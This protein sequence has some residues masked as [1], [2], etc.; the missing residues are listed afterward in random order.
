MLL[1]IAGGLDPIRIQKGLFLFGRETAAPAAEG[2]DFV[3]YNWGPFSRAI[4]GDLQALQAAG[5]VERLPVQGRGY[6][7]YRQTGAGAEESGRLRA[8][9]R[10]ELL[11]SLDR[12]REEIVGDDFRELLRR[13][14]DRYPAFEL[15]P[16]R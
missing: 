3:P 15:V 16:R 11:G 9:A 2:Y 5:L 10:P 12:L 4:Y 8:E 7:L 1:L 6:D 14:Y 13:V